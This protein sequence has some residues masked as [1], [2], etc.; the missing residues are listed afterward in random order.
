MANK[1][2]DLNGF[3]YFINKIIGKT[4]IAGIGDGTLTG[5]ISDLGTE[6]IRRTDYS[7][8][9]F[10]TW[11]RYNDGRVHMYGKKQMKMKITNQDGALYF[12]DRA[13]IYLPCP[14]KFIH[15]QSV[16][17]ASNTGAWATCSPVV[18]DPDCITFWVYAASAYNQNVAMDVFFDVIGG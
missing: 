7:D 1:F 4:S 5:A 8:D 12:A 11:D 6:Y 14:I 2:L 16:T 13:Q 17:I 3:K 10:M 18:T 9:G 15:Y